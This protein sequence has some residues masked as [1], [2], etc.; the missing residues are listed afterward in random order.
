MLRGRTEPE[1]SPSGKEAPPPSPVTTGFPARDQAY[2]TD[3]RPAGILFY[4]ARSSFWLPY[5]LLQT[6]H[7]QGDRLVL[8]FA[9]DEVVLIGRGLHELYVHL[10]R[11]AVWRIVEQGERYAALSDAAVFVARLERTPKE[12]QQHRRE[13]EPP[14]EVDPA[15]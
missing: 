9:T 10:A 13:S 4:P 14:T 2:A 1:P 8:V 6:M 11:Q 3:E 12:Q 15:D 7:C 5:H